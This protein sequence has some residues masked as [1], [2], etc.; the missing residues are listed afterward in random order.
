MVDLQLAKWYT[1]EKLG[2]KQNEENTPFWIGVYSVFWETDYPN[3]RSVKF[4]YSKK[5]RVSNH[6]AVSHAMDEMRRR[7]AARG[8]ETR[9]SGRLFEDSEHVA[10]ASRYPREYWTEVAE[11]L[12][13]AGVPEAGTILRSI[14]GT[15]SKL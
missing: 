11:S 8:R 6:R 10:H 5:D 9:V 3:L 15:K 14:L 4:L 2:A 1:A 13:L 12:S 7:I